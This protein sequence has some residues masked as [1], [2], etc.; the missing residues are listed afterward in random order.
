MSLFS[1]KDYPSSTFGSKI[2][3][4]RSEDSEHHHRHLHRS[5]HSG[6][7]DFT[8]RNLP[9]VA[10]RSFG[11]RHCASIVVLFRT[12]WLPLASAGRYTGVTAAGELRLR[13][14]LTCKNSSGMVPW[15]SRVGAM[16]DF[17]CFITGTTTSRSTYAARGFRKYGTSGRTRSPRNTGSQGLRRQSSTAQTSSPSQR[18]L[19]NEPWKE[20]LG[21]PSLVR[22]TGGCYPHRDKTAL[23]YFSPH[24]TNHVSSTGRPGTALPWQV[25][26]KFKKE[27]AQGL[28]RSDLVH[29][30][31]NE[32]FTICFTSGSEML[33][34]VIHCNVAKLLFHTALHPKPQS[35]HK[36][37]FQR[38]KKRREKNKGNGAPKNQIDNLGREREG[39]GQNE[40][41][42]GS[43]DNARK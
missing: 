28:N 40:R 16:A 8:S 25:Q 23:K 41:D 38:P 42:R 6:I 9:D 13:V 12:C 21:Q 30:L 17:L 5:N 24:W 20:K 39:E 29:N 43:D 36:V 37:W 15:S 22:Q 31:R 3:T 4:Q 32:L 2:S 14:Y 33:H 19:D 26:V 7:L 34:F 11:R 1:P 18:A 35:G 27:S 10:I